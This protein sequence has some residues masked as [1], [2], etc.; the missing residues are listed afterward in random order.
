MRLTPF[1]ETG[2]TRS[3]ALP[4]DAAMEQHIRSL[5]VHM[6]LDGSAPIRFP[7][8]CT[9][10]K[11]LTSL[12]RDKS[13]HS[14]AAEWLLENGRAAEKM[15]LSMTEQCRTRLPAS[16]GTARIQRIAEELVRCSDARISCRRLTDCLRGFDEVRSLTMDE[17]WSAPAALCAALSS[18]YVSIAERTASAYRSQTAAKRPQNASEKSS[19]ETESQDYIRLK[20]ILATLRMLAGLDWAEH[21]PS[22]S[23]AEAILLS[24]PAGTYPLMDEAS[25]SQIRQQV[26]R[27]SRAAN[28]S[29]TTIAQCALDAAKGGSAITSEI[30]WWLHTDE[31]VRA[32]SE[33][34]R[35]AARTRPLVPD[36]HGTKYLC[37][38]GALFL[39][40]SLAAFVLCGA[41]VSIIALP[42]LWGAA[43]SIVNTL[44][45]MIIRPRPLLR[46]KLD[47]IPDEYRTLVV[48]PALLSSPDRA[49]SLVSELETLGCLETDENLSFLLLGDLPDHDRPESE[50]DSAILHAAEEEII[51]ANAHAGC[52]KYYFLHR[53]RSYQACE[54]RYMGKERKRGALSALNRLL[55]TGE[56]DF[57]QP[58]AVKLSGRFAFVITLDAGTRMLPGV[59]HRLICTMAHPLNRRHPS[60]DG[61][62][63]GYS[64]LAPRIELPADA[65]TNSFIEL[66][67]GP[68]GVDSYPTAVSDVYQDACGQGIFGG[69]GIYDIA[70]FD[71]S[72]SGR[73][74]DNL[75]LSHDLIEGLLAGAGFLCD[76][77]LYD[78]QPKTARSYFMRLNRWTRG[79]WQLIPLLLK[80]LPLGA[81]DRY[82][83]L[84]N[85]RRSLEPA[86]QMALLI[87]GFHAHSVAEVFL[88]FLPF[89]LPLLLSPRRAMD[90]LRRLTLR[91][92]MLPQEAFCLLD[93]ISRSLWRM[94]VSHRHLLQWVTAEDAER[95]G[96]SLSPAPGW[97]ASVLLLPALVAP[98]PWLLSDVLVAALWWTGTTLVSALEQPHEPVPSPDAEER[99]LLLDLAAR[100]FR[101]F[102]EN[103]SKSGLPPD[104]I[105]LD[106]PVGAARRTSPTN[107]GLY[108]VSCVAARELGLISMEELA[109]RASETISSLESMEKWNGHIFNWYHPDTLQPLRP[110][111]VSSVDSG[112]LAAC[113]LLTARSLARE[114][115]PQLAERI[116]KIVHQMDF[117]ALYDPQKHLFRIGMDA[118]NG[119]LSDAHYDLLA[120]ESR[121]LSYTAMMLSQVPIKHWHFLGRTAVSTEG[122]C[123]L[124]S[125][126]GTMFEYL[127]PSLFMPVF[128]NT[129]LEQ[130]QSA[131]IRAQ[132][133]AADETD[134]ADLP[135]GVSESGYCACDKE[136]S[137]QYRAFGL[138]HLALRPDAEDGVIAPYASMLALPFYPEE[139]IGNLREMIS[140][141]LMGDYGLYEAM[142]VAPDRVPDGKKTKTIM[143]HM[144][145]HQGMILCAIC[146]FLTDGALI[147]LF[148]D[149]PEARALSLLLQEKPVRRAAYS[150]SPEYSMALPKDAPENDDEADL[151]C[152][153]ADAGP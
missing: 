130:T 148:M 33:E 142:D 99:A 75:I 44:I 31:G 118:E 150:I 82:K 84:D 58:D 25:K 97:I 132:I 133:N 139:V 69:K 144:A 18:E 146:N 34:Y 125:W 87:H 98:A 28:L 81:L 59:A 107:I 64:V 4:D 141:G 83:I 61:G 24:D 37:S 50:G 6:E 92:A 52:E 36:P 138:P 43:A 128:R 22:L 89:L 86:A 140:M 3:G 100:T 102:S 71:S 93:G 90:S 41:C 48:L 15:I 115:C 8:K 1:Q 105:Q 51:R 20:N 26:V 66:Y 77:A 88:G 79:D 145:H 116:E 91:C 49:R 113:L 68:G 72:V 149:R 11:P 53:A 2:F 57:A 147:R 80:K 46:L 40:F 101:F 45:P 32:L 73:L 70:A 119:L 54:R 47:R 60:P 127:M 65:V 19:Y 104:N 38:V 35:L 30:C 78:G 126:S 74:P 13:A 106:P 10:L 96:G 63:R 95:K 56:N 137:Y 123:A 110:R 76:T 136:G 27:L 124:A 117:A 151:L 42:V 16:G 23:R 9:V 29:E 112:N 67:A 121:I 111:Y 152:P 94:T 122:G 108:L 85:L 135:W 39:L 14:P 143:S 103:T 109:E 7:A 114:G 55:L 129:L 131:V 153:S 17:L 21:F 12:T 120:S 5:A 134:R 62:I